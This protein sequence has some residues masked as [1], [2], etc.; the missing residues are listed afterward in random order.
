[1]QRNALLWIGTILV[2]GGGL[3]RG[4]AGFFHVDLV[5]AAL[6]NAAAAGPAV[7]ALVGIAAVAQVLATSRREAEVR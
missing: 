7:S 6:G 1:M 3:N 4:L 5:A 2:L